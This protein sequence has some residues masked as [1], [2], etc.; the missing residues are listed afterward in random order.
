VALGW[1]RKRVLIID[2]DLGKSGRSAEG[3]TGL[4]RLVRGVTLHQVGLRDTGNPLRL[5]I[6]ASPASFAA[7]G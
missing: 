7:N 3:R 1:P 6:A 4:Q 2:E 5:E